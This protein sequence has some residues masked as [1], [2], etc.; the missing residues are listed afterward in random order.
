MELNWNAIGAVGEILGA[1]AVV[2][3]LIYLAKELEHAQSS[4][5]L[6]SGERLL[7]TFDDVNRVIIEDVSLRE[8][9]FKQ[10]PLTNP[11]RLQLYMFAVTK[12]NMW[13][14]AQNAY[15][16]GQVSAELYSGACKDVQVA[17]D[18]W[19]SLLGSFRTRLERYPEVNRVAIF[20]PLREATRS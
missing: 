4:S 19:P 20:D 9:L 11:E 7:R 8:A 6:T 13:L 1:I 16:R 17:I 12:C 2:V 3:T 10:E 5:L 14:S 15:D 18:D